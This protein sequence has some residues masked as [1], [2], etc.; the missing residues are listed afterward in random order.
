MKLAVE[1]SND[2]DRSDVTYKALWVEVIVQATKDIQIRD[3]DLTGLTGRP[4]IHAR[5]TNKSRRKLRAETIS[6]LFEKCP[7]SERVWKY[8]GLNRD[9]WMVILAKNL[10]ITA[11]DT[12]SSLY[13]KILELRM[14]PQGRRYPEYAIRMAKWFEPIYGR[15]P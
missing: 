5:S 11:N 10:S 2:I 6:W 15:T 13:K 4:L 8:T 12:T 9:Y 1:K 3:Q 14:L 7:D